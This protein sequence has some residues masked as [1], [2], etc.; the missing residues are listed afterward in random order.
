MSGDTHPFTCANCGDEFESTWSREDA[1]DEML[2]TL[3]PAHFT[4]DDGPLLP[5]CD[6]CHA[7]ILGRIRREAPHLLRPEAR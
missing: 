7:L 3:D 5:V 1:I 2:D 4:P 6:D